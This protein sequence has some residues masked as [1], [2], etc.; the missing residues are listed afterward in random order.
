MRRGNECTRQCGGGAMVLHLGVLQLRRSELCRMIAG[1]GLSY[2]SQ[3]LVSQ[4][5]RNLCTHGAC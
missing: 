1:C 4:D 3:K 2:T 5:L